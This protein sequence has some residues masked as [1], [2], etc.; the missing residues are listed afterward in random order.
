M[1]GCFVSLG[2]ADRRLIV[3]FLNSINYIINNVYLHYYP[4]DDVNTFI[5]YIGV[6][7]G[8]ILVLL[9]PYILRYKNKKEKTDICIKSNLID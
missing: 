6:S 3:P 1:V 5:Y 8:E 7:I 4:E 2:D 9:V